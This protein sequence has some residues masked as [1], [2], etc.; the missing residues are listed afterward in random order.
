VTH[1]FRGKPVGMPGPRVGLR[2]GTF[3]GF[4]FSVYGRYRQLVLIAMSARAFRNMTSVAVVLL[5]FWPRIGRELSPLAVATGFF[6]VAAATGVSPLADA[7]G[8]LR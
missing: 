1:L 6:T 7:T 3:S 2:R 8:G 5:L 4:P